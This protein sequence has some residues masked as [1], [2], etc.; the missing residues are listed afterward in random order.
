MPAFVHLLDQ[1]WLLELDRTLSQTLARLIFL[2][3]FSYQVFQP[4]HFEEGKEKF[5]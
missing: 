2:H 4:E 1:P 3:A 5:E